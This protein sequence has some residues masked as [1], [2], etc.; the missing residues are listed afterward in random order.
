MRPTFMCPGCC[1]LK[2]FNSLRNVHNSLLFPLCLLY[3]RSAIN[4]VA[5]VCFFL[6]CFYRKIGLSL[7]IFL[8]SSR[9][10][11]YSII[12]WSEL[13]TRCPIF[14][15]FTDK[16]VSVQSCKPRRDILR[17]GRLFFLLNTCMQ[18]THLYS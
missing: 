9:S 17:L 15:R 3:I 7:S 10:F 6:N 4:S 5:K 14:L 11:D 12:L 18:G 2:A 1:P 16:L 13:H 8:C